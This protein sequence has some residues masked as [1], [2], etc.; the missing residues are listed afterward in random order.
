M[1]RLLERQIIQ[2]ERDMDKT[3]EKEV[4]VLGKLASTLEKLIEIDRAERPQPPTRHKDMQELRISSP[5][6]L[7]SSRES[8]A[9]L[10][11][12]EMTNP[13]V[14]RQFYDW[15]SW[16]RAEQLPPEATGRPG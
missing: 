11:V 3:G 9:P 7:P 2:L 15:P 4:A 14:E 6:A 1:F 12:A 10:L 16:A 13:T 5:F 8:E